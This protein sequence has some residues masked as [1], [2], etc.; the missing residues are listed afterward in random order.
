MKKLRIL[1]ITSTQKENETA[2]KKT[3]SLIFPELETATVRPPRSFPSSFL[4]LLLSLCSYSP[5]TR[6]M[7][8]RFVLDQIGISRLS[9]QEVQDE[10]K[11]EYRECEDNAVECTEI[12]LKLIKSNVLKGA[13]DISQLDVLRDGEHVSLAALLTCVQ[14]AFT[15]KDAEV[16]VPLS[17]D[18]E[19]DVRTHF[20]HCKSCD[21]DA[22]ELADR[23][24]VAQVTVSQKKQ[25]PLFAQP[26]PSR[27]EQPT[28]LMHPLFGLYPNA[29]SKDGLPV[30]IP[31][32][33]TWSQLKKL[34]SAFQKEF[35]A[36]VLTMHKTFVQLQLDTFDALPSD[37]QKQAIASEKA[38]NEQD[39]AAAQQAVSAAAE[40]AASAR[41]AAAAA[42]SIAL[43][44]VV[45]IAEQKEADAAANVSDAN[46]SNNNSNNGNGNNNSNNSNTNTNS[47]SNNGES[48][49]GAQSELA[50]PLVASSASGVDD[51]AVVASNVNID[52]VEQPTVQDAANA[53]LVSV[54]ASEVAVE[55]DEIA[56]AI[57]IPKKLSKSDLR[58]RAIARVE[59]PIW[60]LYSH[61]RERKVFPLDCALYRTAFMAAWCRER[62][63]FVALQRAYEERCK[64]QK[65]NRSHVPA[66]EP[67]APLTIS[68][69]RV[70]IE[71]LALMPSFPPEDTP[72][73]TSRNSQS[74]LNG[75]GASSSTN[76]G[77]HNNANRTH[78]RSGSNTS[79]RFLSEQDPSEV[80]YNPFP[81]SNRDHRRLISVT[82]PLGAS[83]PEDDEEDEED[84][85]VNSAANGVAVA[86]GAA[87]ANV[88][89]TV[90]AN[91]NDLA[92]ALNNAMSLNANQNAKNQTATIAAAT[93]SIAESAALRI[94]RAEKELFHRLVHVL[95]EHEQHNLLDDET[96]TVFHNVLEGMAGLY[97]PIQRTQSAL[98]SSVRAVADVLENVAKVAAEILQ[99]H[100]HPRP[101]PAQSMSS[102]F[103]SARTMV[104]PVASHGGPLVRIT[105]QSEASFHVSPQG[106][107]VTRTCQPRSFVQ[108]LSML[109]AKETS[110]HIQAAR[111]Q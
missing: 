87:V 22:L 49:V 45:Q 17:A 36:Q 108:N 56:L 57:V 41:V 21:V 107:K 50:S 38:L 14:N 94:L 95:L 26:D 70:E 109:Q 24:K 88:D 43:S 103:A 75:G 15:P 27:M 61:L 89:A 60:A 68:F 64:E 16:E 6:E 91:A 30:L 62:D 48:A 4:L 42:A 99:P 97:K 63:D 105:P 12:R 28:F 74:Q 98:Q 20:Y 25:V 8:L 23:L 67:R 85:V 82:R 40:I 100:P 39:I 32:R 55:E 72:S 80:P 1:F 34:W 92:N 5:F 37:Q 18:I 78:S 110:S 13:V 90:N 96:T 84:A 83:L 3:C 19:R 104:A 46:N 69:D 102:S 52:A 11:Q 9:P 81:T 65:R 54:V 71:M 101:Q 76:N 73:Q 79:A 77:A 44:E 29:G 10:M 7:A 66:D 106:V 53:A 58:K 35:A 86:A 31:E 111:R 93:N 51:P 59:V 47:N 2:K 33:L